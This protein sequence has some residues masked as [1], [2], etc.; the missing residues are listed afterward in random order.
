MLTPEQEKMLDESQHQ[1]RGGRRN[2]L[3]GHGS[4]E[5]QSGQG[6]HVDQ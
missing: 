5:E 4:Q 6:Q 1:R 2:G 3:R